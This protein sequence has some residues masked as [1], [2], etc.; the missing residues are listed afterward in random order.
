VYGQWVPVWVVWGGDLVVAGVVWVEPV[1]VD[2][3]ETQDGD[4]SA[5]LEDCRCLHYETGDAAGKLKL[6]RRTL[7]TRRVDCEQPRSPGGKIVHYGSV[8]RNATGHK[9]SLGF[10]AVK[11]KNVL[12]DVGLAA[13]EVVVVSMVLDDV[14]TDD[15]RE[16]APVLAK[17]NLLRESSERRASDIVAVVVREQVDTEV[18]TDGKLF[19][20]G[21]TAVRRAEKTGGGAEPG[22]V[23][24]ETLRLDLLDE[25]CGDRTAVRA[26]PMDVDLADELA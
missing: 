2:I 14:L 19:R 25:C 26:A 22:A 6:A 12:W 4:V 21:G 20:A 8:W 10:A 13:E 1:R 18:A 17:D 15:L 7:A 3:V 24:V 5:R 16:R 9:H 23:V 11:H